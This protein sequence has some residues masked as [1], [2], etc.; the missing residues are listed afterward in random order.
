VAVTQQWVRTLRAQGVDLVVALTHMPLA[1]ER[2]LLQQVLD[3]DLCLA[4][5][6]HIFTHEADYG[7]NLVEG[8]VDLST[9]GI[10]TISY[11]PGTSPLIREMSFENIVPDDSIPKDVE[12]QNLVDKWLDKFD[13]TGNIVVGMTDVTLHANKTYLRVRETNTGNFVADSMRDWAINSLTTKDNTEGIPVVAM[14]NS[15]GL[16]WVTDVA[17]GMNL[18]KGS[19]LS[20]LPFGDLATVVRA[21][22]SIL[23]LALENSVSQIPASDG[24]FMQV[25]GFKFVYSCKLNEENG[26]CSVPAGSRV[27]NMTLTNGTEIVDTTNLFIVCPD[28]TSSG[29]DSNTFFI[30]LELVIDGESGESLFGIVLQ[31]VEQMG[32]IS[33]IEEGRIVQLN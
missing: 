31:K 23:R 22:G 26:L 5:H 3:V 19:I 29:G 13:A 27:I 33:P 32:V 10:I 21:T 28:F 16:R 18:T 2:L 8:D 12:M 11:Y 9:L 25:G 14:V 1:N 15:G 6:D 4:G 20:L 7:V 24:R 30:G 17:A